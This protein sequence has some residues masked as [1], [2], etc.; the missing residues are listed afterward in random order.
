[1][2]FYDKQRSKK[3]K[4]ASKS[5]PHSPLARGVGVDLSNIK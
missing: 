2:F 1:M 5:Q 4:A 3:S